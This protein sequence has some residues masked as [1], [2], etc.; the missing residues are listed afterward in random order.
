M[1][2]LP[3]TNA[4]PG[5]PRDWPPPR[6][7]PTDTSSTSLAELAGR[8][9]LHPTFFCRAFKQ[10]TGLSPP[11]IC[12]IGLDCGFGSLSQF[13]A[14]FKRITGVSP[15]TGRAPRGLSDKVPGKT[16][17]RQTVDIGLRLAAGIAA[18]EARLGVVHGS[19][20]LTIDVQSTRCG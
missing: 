10:L 17:I 5:R 18:M 20:F 4:S 13:S 1:R 15:R 9:Q 19:G 11:V 12:G 7:I 16:N 8:L 6:A 14:V 2:T 3:T